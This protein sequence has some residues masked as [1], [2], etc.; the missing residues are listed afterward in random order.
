VVDA[1]A[2][3]RSWV[4]YRQR[5]YAIPGVSFAIAHD[6]E[7]VAAH[8][9]GKAD[10]ERDVDLR[11]DHTFR[12]ASHS[13]TFTA[14]AVLQLAERGRLRLDDT[15]GTHVPWLDADVHP[16]GRTTLRELLSHSAG[17]VRDGIDAPWWGLR[18]P[19]LDRDGLRAATT[20]TAPVLE[21]NERF[22]YS[23]IGYSLLG[24]VVADAAGE[25]YEAY[26]RANVIEPLGLTSTDPEPRAD[27]P[28]LAVGH[29]TRRYGLDRRPFPHLDTRAM[30]SATG[31]SSTAADLCRYFGAHALGTGE[32]LTDASKREM[33]HG[34]WEV[35][36]GRGGH[37]G[38]GFHTFSIGARRVVSHSGGFPGFITFSLVDPVDRLAVSVLTNAHDGPAETIAVALVRLVNR[39]AEA[40]DPGAAERARLDRCT[41]RFLGLSNVV[42]L[43]RL[44]DQLLVI[45]PE[46]LD[47]VVDATR[48]EP[49]DG[50][51]PDRFRLADDGG[52]GS[53][54]EGARFERDGDGA[55][56]AVQL[57]G[58]RYVPREEM[59]AHLDRVRAPRP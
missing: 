6:G 1:A 3:A 26:V 15:A 8:A 47:P 59:V 38:L 56:S 31:F 12:I 55:L 32:L 57:A 53:Y 49:V 16:L 23:N 44:G 30:A 36:G 17:V 9:V 35:K 19:F 54:G 43:V 46:A 48:L 13:K 58:G 22:K 5:T 42:D 11:T 28:R 41:G 29:S 40:G 39:A 18:G 27:D 45:D 33:Q 21:R 14:T 24:E 50:D 51:D 20:T 25:P 37:Y 4:E 52:F 7:V 10:L 34:A 2:Y